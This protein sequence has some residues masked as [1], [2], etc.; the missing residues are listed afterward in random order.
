MQV[1]SDR[2][3]FL[4]FHLLRAPDE[5]GVFL[6]YR[7][8]ETIYIGMSRQSIRHA[9]VNLLS[10]PVRPYI[11]EGT[12]FSCELTGWPLSRQ[13]DLLRRHAELHGAEPRCQQALP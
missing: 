4:D 3:P 13:K 6:L 9:L 5:P 2:Y 12:N 7:D 10:D 11:L 1:T 8:A